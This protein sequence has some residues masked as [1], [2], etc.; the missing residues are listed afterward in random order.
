MSLFSRD[1]LILLQ[2]HHH[3]WVSVEY[4]VQTTKT[5]YS[6]GL[7][8]ECLPALRHEC[9][10]F[11]SLL[12][13]FCLVLLSF[14]LHRWGLVFCKDSEGPHADFLESLVCISHSFLELGPATSCYLSLPELLCLLNSSARLPCSAR[15]SL[16]PALL[17]GMILPGRNLGNH[18]AYLICFS[19]FRDHS[20]GLLVA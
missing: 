7:E 4:L 18:R 6:S 2:R 19:Y 14:T 11:T 3:S 9:W 17:S 13:L 15:D 5:F 12:L 8:F 10:K 20:P 16:P 1:S